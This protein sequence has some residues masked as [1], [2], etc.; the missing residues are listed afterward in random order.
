MADIGALRKQIADLEAQLKQELGKA[1]AEKIK[2]IKQAI[3]EFGLTSEEL[4]FKDASGAAESEKK[5]RAKAG[6]KYALEVDG[7]PLVW[8]G[9]GRMPKPYQDYLDAD[10]ARTLEALLIK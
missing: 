9:R 3:K 7:K 8:S 10:G 5:T 6:P 4:G 2:E 1:K